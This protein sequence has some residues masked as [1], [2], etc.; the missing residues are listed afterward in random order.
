MS[1][2]YVWEVA[3]GS[4]QSSYHSGGGVLI[5]TD[6]DP[7]AVWREHVASRN[8]D[9]SQWGEPLDPDALDDEPDH[10][11]PADSP[12]LLVVFPDAGCC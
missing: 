12:D 11:F 10:T 5:V 1:T 8:A 4:V 9:R 7:R 6:G 2:A 3:S